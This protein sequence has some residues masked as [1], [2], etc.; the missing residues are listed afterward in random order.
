LSPEQVQKLTQLPI[1]IV[2]P[3]SIPQGFRVVKAD[4]GSDK[5][6]NGDDD[7]GYAIEYERDDNTC[8]AIQTSKDGPRGLKSLGQVDSA[9]GAIQIYQDRGTLLSFVP[10]AKGNPVI[11]SP[12]SR[13]NPATG[14]YVKCQALQ[15]SEYESILKSLDVVK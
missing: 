6:V 5:L 7:A 11:L 15:R 12:L 1:T 9:L 13:L 10:V 14:N 3:T 4:G 2:A 8:F